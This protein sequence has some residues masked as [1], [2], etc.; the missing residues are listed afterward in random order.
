MA[1]VNVAV[2]SAKPYDKKYLRTALAHRQ[3]TTSNAGDVALA[4]HDF[5]L[6]TDTVPLA[7]GATA[8][9]AFVNDGLG[10]AVLEAL[11][12]EGVGAVLLRCAGYNNVDLAAA[13]RLGLFVASVPSYSPE[14]V[15]EFSVALLQTLNRQTHRAYNRVREGNF[16]LDGLLG[17]TLHGKTVGI[18]GVGRIGMAAAR[19]LRCGYGCRVLAFDPHASDEAQAEFAALAGTTSGEKSVQDSVGTPENSDSSKNSLL[20]PATPNF[21]PSIAALLPHCDFISLHCPLTE[22]TRHLINADA[23]AHAKP[24][25]LLVN[26]SRGGLID[27]RAVIAA[28]KEHRLGGLALDVYESEGSLFYDD[29]SGDIIDDDQLMRLMTFPNVI[30]CGHQAFFTEEALTEI[31]AG[32]LQNLD[33]FLLA[34]P[35]KNVL[36]RAHVPLPCSSITWLNQVVPPHCPVT[37]GVSHAT[38]LPRQKLKSPCLRVD[39]HSQ[40]NIDGLDAQ[41]THRTMDSNQ[42]DE[43]PGDIYVAPGNK[44]IQV[45]LVISLALGLFGFFSFCI[46]RPRWKSL[47]AARRQTVHASAALPVLP[48]SFFGWLPVLYN[49]TEDQVLASA[50][51]DAFVF[52]AFFKMSLKLFTVM[53]F[54][55]AVVL[56]PINRHFVDETTAV[57]MV[58][59][60]VDDDPDE[61]DS[62]NRAKGHL[63]AYLVFI[64]FF[65]FLTYYFMSRETFRVIKVRQEYLGSQATVTDRTFRLTGIPKEF[66]SEDKIKTLVEKLEIGRVDSVTVCRKW[67]A[68]DALVADR[69]QLLQTLEETWASYL[70]QK[71]ERA[72]AGVVRRDDEEEGLLPADTDALLSNSDDNVENQ[73]L[74]RKRPQVRIWYG[75]M[76]LQNRKTDALDYYGEKLRLLDE[77]ICAARRQ[78]YEATELA[79]VTMDSVAACQMAIQ[80]LLDPRPGEL[81]ARMAPSPSDIIWPNTYATRTQRRLHAWAITIFIT[82]LSIVWLVPVASLASLLSL[83]TIQKWAPALAHMLAR[84]GI[85]KALVQTGLPTAVVSLL[86][87]AVPYLYEFLSYR[88]GM[89][90]RGDVE[91]SIISKNFFFTFFNIFLVFTV[92]G[93]ATG[94]WAVLRDSLHDTTYIAYALARE[95]QRLSIFYLNFIMLQSLGLFPLRLLEFG[96]IALYPIA[97]LAAR[98]PR[99]LAR[100]VNTPPTFSYGFY[101]PTAMLVFILCLVYSVLPRGFL[102]LALGSIYFALGALTYKY[103]LL[104]AMDQPQHATGGAWR[105]ICYRILLGLAV[106]HLTMSG[107]LG[108]NKAFVQATLVIPLFVFTVWYMYYFRAHFEPL[109]RNIALL[110]VRRDGDASP[111]SDDE[112]HSGLGNLTFARRRRLRRT[113]TLNDARDKSTGFVNPSLVVPLEQPWIYHDPPPLIPVSDDDSNESPFDNSDSPNSLDPQSA[114]NTGPSV[115]PPGRTLDR[116]ASSSFSLGDTHIWRDNLAP[117][118]ESA[119]L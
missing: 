21:L 45:Q 44:D 46:L 14:A 55:A 86:N 67:G 57:T 39:A 12:A 22:S 84:H 70:A 36:V 69:R 112:L 40:S 118:D 16:S 85:T 5:A 108:A 25:A 56:E 73:P 65:T 75:V 18:V 91:L 54:F 96:S 113:S 104:Y 32:T 35:C 68:L 38:S 74:L 78:E 30:V 9:C 93:T 7:R 89:L 71:P 88:Q 61:D 47:Y 119:S 1:P 92:F 28:L 27:T 98:T 79:F 90:S 6:S 43:C 117:A 50:G 33:D 99:D 95:V 41:C 2:F 4:F 26:T 63:W 59:S 111:L 20:H 60:A 62:W 114:P 58:T 81:L 29:H 53:F 19:I 49:I 76:H 51:L 83:C 24:G 72:P 116:S 23:L 11:A 115:V 66:R 110:S 107:Y 42:T 82:I 87:V 17:R 101:L 77:Q 10:V 31:A 52:L 102:G 64:Y 80:A 103:Q 106:F 34:R 97:R 15:A 48:D 105:I 13:E 3:A 94:I 8:V 100:L 109:T 37:C